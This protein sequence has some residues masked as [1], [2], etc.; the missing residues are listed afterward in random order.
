MKALSDN[1]ERQGLHTEAHTARLLAERDRRR[2]DVAV[3]LLNQSARQ[4]LHLAP[5][6]NTLRLDARIQTISPS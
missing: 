2:N 3:G 1:R 5:N 6:S 4:R